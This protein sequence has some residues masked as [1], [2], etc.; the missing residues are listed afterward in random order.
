ML[1]NPIARAW[2]QLG[3]GW[4]QIQ[5]LVGLYL[6][7]VAL[8]SY[9]AYRLA[10]PDDA[11]QTTGVLLA[12]VSVLQGVFILTLAPGAVHKA[13]QRDHQTK[14]LE[15]HRLSP[16]RGLTMAVGYL[17][18]PTAH[19]S[20]L[21]AAGLLVGTLLAAWYG[22]T[23]GLVGPI[24]G[25]WL[26]GQLCLLAAAGLL[27]VLALLTALASSGKV[28]ILAMLI[29]T[30]F[31]GGW[32]LVAFVPGLALVFGVLTIGML[33]QI[34]TRSALG[35]ASDP[36]VMI[37]SLLMQGALTAVLLRACS[38]RLRLPDQPAFSIRLG[39]LLFVVSGV[40]LCAGAR[41][42]DDFRW[43]FSTEYTPAQWIGSCI[44][45]LVIVLFPIYAAAIERAQI[46]RRLMVA[47]RRAPLLAPADATVLLVAMLMVLLAWLLDYKQ[48]S[49][50]TWWPSGV[51]LGVVV[52]CSSWVDYAW[53]CI[54]RRRDRSAFRA[55]LFS[56]VLF[57]ALPLM[58]DGITLALMEFTRVPGDMSTAQ[59]AWPV[60][61]LSPIG[62]FILAA[63]GRLSWV[64]V[65]FQLLIAILALVAFNRRRRSDEFVASRRTAVA[66]TPL[67]V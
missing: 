59:L 22:Q 35:P 63:Q 50:V 51:A 16:M 15:S 24:V 28:N 19:A 62:T 30:S 12:I 40:A 10:G 14:M 52:L 2:Q 4:R 47:G 49:F 25:A 61:N 39:L 7:L 36:F 57:K 38:R 20:A 18:G 41:V 55:L 42:F 31:L 37:W 65:A 17:L 3:G 67:T 26:F 29:I 9:G 54:A 45:G 44:A 46:D 56:A 43:L 33:L 53:M 66:A 11:Q 58:I 27:L 23:A 8:V 5:V 60:S 34:I 6:A 64:G 21:F 1:D 13:V 48:D 32:F